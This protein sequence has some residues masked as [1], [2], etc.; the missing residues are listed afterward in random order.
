MTSVSLK[1]KVNQPIRYDFGWSVLRQVT[2]RSLDRFHGLRVEG[3]VGQIAAAAASFNCQIV[4]YV[5]DDYSGPVSCGRNPKLCLGT[6]FIC[7][8]S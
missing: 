6:P 5:P 4:H 1:L 3:E 8:C 2:D 7:F